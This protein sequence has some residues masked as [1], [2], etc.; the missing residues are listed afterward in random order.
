M[1]SSI[2]R[3]MLL[4]CPLILTEILIGFFAGIGY[5]L[6]L[7]FLI[8]T[9]IRM[10]IYSPGIYILLFGK[11]HYS[12]QANSI[13]RVRASR[14]TMLLMIFNSAVL[15]ALAVVAILIANVKLIDHI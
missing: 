3:I 1:K 8:Y 9:V 4:S 13:A 12:S 14:T 7:L 6:L 2:S 5:S 10:S 11:E 15:L